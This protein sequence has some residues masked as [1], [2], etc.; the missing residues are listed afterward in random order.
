MLEELITQEQMKQLRANRTD[1][2]SENPPVVQLSWNGYPWEM[3]VHS[4][5]ED[6]DTLV[7]I[8]EDC[9]EAARWGETSL[10]RINSI[11][12]GTQENGLLNIRAHDDF[13]P[14]YAMHRFS[15]AA[16]E[17]GI[18]PQTP[19]MFCDVCGSYYP[20]EEPCIQH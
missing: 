7:G 8:V 12:N 14:G 5:N 3:L 2:N 6:E 19:G 15:Y 10:T 4:I 16:E 1:E 17:E 20:G 9:K 18:I 13:E 11:F